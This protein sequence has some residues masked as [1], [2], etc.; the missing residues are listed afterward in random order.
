MNK[1]IKLSILLILLNV[2][3][4]I[5]TT[6]IINSG[7]SELNPLLI[8]FILK[9]GVFSGLCLAKMIPISM[10]IIGVY[11]ST[12]RSVGVDKLNLVNAMLLIVCVCYVIVC[13]YS[14]GLILI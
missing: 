9:F 11:L 10:I 14:V 4:V 7:G 3:D 2:L 1:S 12:K 13:A 5:L 6:I 8:P